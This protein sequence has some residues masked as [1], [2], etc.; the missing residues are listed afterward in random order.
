LPSAASF[1]KSISRSSARF[2]ARRGYIVALER[3][4]LALIC[5]PIFALYAHSH[6]G[7]LSKGVITLVDDAKAHR[8][9]T[10]SQINEFERQR[11]IDENRQREDYLRIR[12]EK[13]ALI[14][15]SWQISKKA[16][17]NEGETVSVNLGH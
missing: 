4:G 12:E 9:P 15:S 6:V 8:T 14:T 16:N 7:F 3:S 1:A 10:E 2:D 13:R 5:T 17:A 11:D